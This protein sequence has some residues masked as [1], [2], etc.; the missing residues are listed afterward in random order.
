MKGRKKSTHEE[1]SVLE[2]L[3]VSVFKAFSFSAGCVQP[4]LGP[5]PS[6]P[7]L[8]TIVMLGHELFLFCT[9]HCGLQENG[10]SS[11]AVFGFLLDSKEINRNHVTFMPNCIENYCD[12]F[13]ICA[14]SNCYFCIT[15]GPINV[16]ISL[17]GKLLW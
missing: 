12:L 5:S 9:F 4:D 2:S 3:K 14:Q 10:Q 7:T 11:V 13:Q 16:V 17:Q 15:I 8:Q 6:A 1:K